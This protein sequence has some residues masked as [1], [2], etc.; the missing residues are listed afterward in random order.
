MNPPFHHVG[1]LVA[2]WFLTNNVN[3]SVDSGFDNIPN[4]PFSTISSNSPNANSYGYPYL[5][6]A[7]SSTSISKT[8][9]GFDSINYLLPDGLAVVESQITLSNLQVAGNPEIGVW[10][11]IQ[12]NWDQQEVTWLESSDGVQW[13]GPGAT[14]PSDRGNLLDS[15][16]I[17]SG[18]KTTWNIT[19]AM[20]ESMRDNQSLN[21]LLDVLPGQSNS[22]ALFFSPLT[23]N[24]DNLPTVEII[25][26]PGSNMKPIPPSASKPTKQWL[27][28]NN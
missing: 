16:M 19:R 12:P 25:Y 24:I 28:V 8:L 9:L 1:K 17:S 11:L 2:W 18:A 20:Q 15:Q 13:S 22:N 6:V 5:S 10:E 21:L 27:F 7:Q 3:N 14:G 26:S 23:G 4:F